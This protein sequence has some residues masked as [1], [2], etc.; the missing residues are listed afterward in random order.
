MTNNFYEIK[1]QICWERR[2]FS[3]PDTSCSCR[4]PSDCEFGYDIVTFED[5]EE[6]CDDL[7]ITSEQMLGLVKGTHLV[8][9]LEPTVAMRNIV[10]SL[11][12]RVLYMYQ[13]ILKAAQK[14]TP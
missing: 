10:R 6:L 12:P 8:G 3:D 5:L 11:T 1:R 14:E 7:N 4:A 9:P 13:E 2:D